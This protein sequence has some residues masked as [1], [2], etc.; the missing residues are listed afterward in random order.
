MNGKL[1]ELEPEIANVYLSKV[2]NVCFSL[3]ELL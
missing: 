2:I 1:C 3:D